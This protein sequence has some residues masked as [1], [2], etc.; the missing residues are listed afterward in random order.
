MR[1]TRTNLFCDFRRQFA[2]VVIGG[3][4]GAN[5]FLQVSF[6]LARLENYVIHFVLVSLLQL[7]DCSPRVVLNPLPLL[8]K[9]LFFLLN[10]GLHFLLLELFLFLF[11]RMFL[12][13]LILGLFLLQL[14]LCRLLFILRIL[15]LLQLDQLFLPLSVRQPFLFKFFLLNFQLLLMQLY[16]LS[17][18]LFALLIDHFLLKGEFAFSCRSLGLFSFMLLFQLPYHGIFFVN[19]LSHF[20]VLFAFSQRN[21][22]LESLNSLESRV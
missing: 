12:L 10:L 13:K 15:L 4:K 14:Q 9:F 19:F 7:V 21:V 20:Q 2:L 5:L 3:F 18:L 11:E 17:L 22:I 1:A 16:V 6:R 8:Q